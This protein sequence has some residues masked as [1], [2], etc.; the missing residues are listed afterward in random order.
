MHSFSLFLFYFGA[1]LIMASHFDFA[2]CQY[3]ENG[4]DEDEMESFE[5]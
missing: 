3:D 5:M 1:L 4:F 2:N